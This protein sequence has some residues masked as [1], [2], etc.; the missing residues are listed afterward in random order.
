MTD[1]L[2]FEWMDIHPHFPNILLR[3]MVLQL[4]KAD[5]ILFRPL[6]QLQDHIL[7]K[8][9]LIALAPGKCTQV[10]KRLQ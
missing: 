10:H 4:L 9:H 7:M 8:I 6:D 5:P 1:I 3:N 2:P